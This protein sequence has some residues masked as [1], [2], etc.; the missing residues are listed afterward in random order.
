MKG[1]LAWRV[2]PIV[3]DDVTKTYDRIRNV[4]DGVSLHVDAGEVVL[5]M[6]RSGSGKTTLLNIVSGL[7]PPTTG[8]VVVSGTDLSSLD[9]QTR[10][11]TRLEGIGVVFQ[12]FHLIPE[13]TVEENVQLPMKLADREDAPT[14]SRELLSFFGIGD[15]V[16][17]FPS[18][19]SGG[20]TQRA[21]IARALANEPDVVLAD[22]PTA[23]LDEDN[24]RNALDALQDVANRL[25]TA[26][27]VASHDPL[28]TSA[29]DRVLYLADGT[30]S[31]ER[32]ARSTPPSSTSEAPQP[33]QGNQDQATEA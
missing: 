29:A 12:R 8:R 20:E 17:A 5:V 21:A 22:E 4:L 14:R 32:P 25:D 16:E 18:T 1:D 2:R 6:G 15:Q 19:L 10:T 28:V 23:N 24:A 9:E 33:N 7:E 11:R 3:V 26:V 31:D 30:L 13:L 27:L